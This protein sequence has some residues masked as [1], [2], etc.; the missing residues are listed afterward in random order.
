MAHRALLL[1]FGSVVLSAFSAQA[2]PIVH[3]TLQSQPGEFIGRGGNFDILYTEPGTVIS[4]NL[5]DFLSPGQP[6]FLS[7]VMASTTQPFAFVQFSTTQ[8]GIPLQPGI[9]LDAQRASLADPG[10]PGVDI[11]FDGEE[12][13]TL[14]GSFTITDISFAPDNT[15]RSFAATFQMTGDNNPALL[16]GSVTFADVPEPGTLSLLAC[17]GLLVT[18][19]ALRSTRRH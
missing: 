13:N 3:L 6:A 8:L 11:A 9:Y 5:L 18:A 15:L 19:R 17:A 16:T 7:L 14:S 4:A 10:H 1:V 2:T 12:H